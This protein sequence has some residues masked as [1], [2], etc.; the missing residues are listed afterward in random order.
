MSPIS[1]RRPPR[2]TIDYETRSTCSLRACG[3]WRYSID[4]TT[5]VL[6]FAYR[7]PGWQEGRVELWHPAFSTLGLPETGF[8]Q[9]LELFQWID[10][11]GL[12]EAH[13]VA[14]ESA[15]W[16]NVSIPRY[17]WPTIRLEQYRCSAAKAAVHSLPRGLDAAAA[18]LGIPQRKDA[19]GSTVMRKMTSPRNPVIKERTAWGVLH[20][21]CTACEGKGKVPGVNPET[22]R[23]KAQPCPLCAGRGYLGDLATLPPMPT[24]YHE[25]PELLD[26]LFAYCRQDVL[27]EE[28]VSRAL[29]DLSPDET[30]VFLLDRRINERG[31]QLDPDAIDT[32]LH[33]IDEEFTELN[34]ELAELTG[35]RVTKTSQRAKMLEWFADQGLSLDDTQAATITELLSDKY[36]H[37]P[38]VRRGLE[39][40]QLLGKS[41]TAKYEA[42]VNWMCPDARVRGG[43]LYHGASTGRWTGV[44]VQPHNFPRGTLSKDYLSDPDLLWWVLKSRDRDAINALF[45]S[46]MNGLSSGLRG[47]IV[48]APGKTL[49]V[50]DYAAI[51]ARV[52]LWAADDEDGLNIFRRNEDIYSDMA[53]AI[54]GRRINRKVDLAEGQLGKVAILGLGY[55]MGATK[56]VETAAT[57]GI[58]LQEYSPCARCEQGPRSAI[59]RRGDKGHDYVPTDPEAMTAVRVVEAYRTKFWRVKELWDMQ[60]WAAIQAVKNQGEHVE[61]GHVTWRFDYSGFLYC[62]LPSGRWLAYPEPQVRLK[63]M[64]WGKYK[65]SLSY[66]GVNAYTRQWTRNDAYGGLLV[67]NQ[68]QAIARD[69]LAG[70]MLRCEQSGVYVPVLSVHDE[71]VTEA[72]TGKGGVKEFN[73]LME[74]VPPWAEGC[75][76]KAEAWAGERYRK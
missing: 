12:V 31:F 2:A 8:D 42:M 39:L 74:W 58:E 75:P 64:P 41:S 9:L 25:S 57:F 69:L 52:L 30:E 65:P 5:E 1:A 4:P 44:G 10:D 26:A 62:T 53:T 54:Y 49:Y 34:A 13:N 71:I 33:L 67:E 29:P 47:A 76:I 36:R 45:G 48:A 38:P 35:G 73:A 20:A 11:G 28:A 32:A 56:F 6:C 37:T 23:R 43:L 3:S 60:E 51:E 22:G 70:A 55:Q 59:H 19:T 27:V 15:I 14:F 66:M 50:A 17:G 21:P 61:C 46:V 72:E 68:V 24:V 7:L 18:A 16:Q 63:M 40:M